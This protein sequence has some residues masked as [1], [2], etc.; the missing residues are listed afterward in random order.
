LEPYHCFDE[1]LWRSSH[2]LVAEPPGFSNL[3]FPSTAHFIGPLI[4]RLNVPLPD[5]ILNL[6]RDLPI[7]YFAMGSSGWP[8]IVARIIA[9]FAGKLYRVI[10]PVKYQLDKQPVQ[11]PDNVLVTDWLLALEVNRLAD[12]AVTHGGHGTVMNA[13]LS[14]KPVVSVAI[15]PEQFLN[16]ECLVAKGFAIRIPRCS[17]TPDR[18]CDSIEKL[19]ADKTAQ[20]KAREYQK[21]IEEWDNPQHIRS[22][23]CETFG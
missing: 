7:V 8:E 11:I 18:L 3:Q 1:V 22:F 6:P 23:F 2:Q 5:E 12:I 15:S 14:G 10:A 21:V 19:L 17:L 16:L 9:G 4:A 13:C 20:D